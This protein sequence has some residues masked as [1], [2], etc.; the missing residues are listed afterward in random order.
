MADFCTK[1]HHE[2]GFPGEPDVDIIK[3]SLDLQN[4]YMKDGYL[5]ESC[6]L[7]GIAKDVNGNLLVYRSDDEGWIL[8]EG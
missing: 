2:M 7:S 8:Y 3:E 1:C 4:G 5:C 6:G